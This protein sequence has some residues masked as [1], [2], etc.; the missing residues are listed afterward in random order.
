[1]EFKY[2]KGPSLRRAVKALVDFACGSLSVLVA[3]ALDRG[4]ASFGV[5]ET[6]RLALAVGGFLVAAEAL[7]GSYRTMWRYAGFQEAVVI[8]TCSLILLTVL[9]AGRWT[10]LVALSMSTVLLIVLLTLFS[11]IGMRALRR[12]Q[13]AEAKRRA[14]QRR[15]ARPMPSA[16]RLAQPTH[17]ILIAGAGEHGLSISRELARSR[18]QGVELIGFVDDDPDKIDVFLDGLPV[19]GT[20][21]EVLAVADQYHVTEVLVAMPSADPDLVRS[22]VRRV[23]ESGIRVRTVRGVAR[24]VMGQDLHRPGG[25]TLHELLDNAGLNGTAPDNGHHARRVL[26]TG[27]AGYVGSHLARMLLERGYQVRILDRF[28]YGDVGI[29]GLRHPHLEVVRGDICSSR[30][31]GK[32]LRDVEAVAALAAI[33]GDPACNLDPEETINLNYTATKMLIDA[34]NFHGARRLVFASSCSVYGA[35]GHDLLTERSRLNP[36]SLYARTRVLSETIIFDRHGEVE[37]VA[38][39]LATVF[40]LSPRM[41]FDLVVNTLTAQAV[42]DRKIA[43]FG[44]NQWRPHVHCRDAARAF[45]MALQAPAAA[46]AGEIFNVG[47]D[48]LN[49]R[50]HDIGTMVAQIVGD[51]EV[52]SSGD[53]TDPRDYRVSFEK[54][55]RAIG[56]EPEFT[57]ADGI[58]EVAAAVAA[59]PALQR[60]RDPVYHNVQALRQSLERRMDAPALAGAAMP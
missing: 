22:L 48:R 42:V 34:C 6:A 24:F 46:V 33:V 38:L 3:I 29:A 9:L 27:G 18:P 59:E 1:M 14:I 25:A 54:I 15:V 58:Q 36:V 45:A 52:R 57:V 4:I 39:R 20:L 49:H 35:N 19:L 53:V 31:L 8:T 40:G 26:I 5:S 55:R 16:R 32:A 2:L 17:R 60:Y 23:E 37:P 56:F 43:I 12:W 13:V 30:D 11:C 51:V 21:S 50:I 47:G 44:G 7:V 28:D 41:R 10:G